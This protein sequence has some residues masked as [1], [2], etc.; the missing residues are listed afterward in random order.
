MNNPWQAIFLPL[1]VILASVGN[2]VADRTQPNVVIIYGDDVGYADVGV[3]GATKI[4][5]PNID[6]LAAQS[7][8][9]TDGHCSAST[10]TPSRFSLLTGVHAFRQGVRIAPPNASLLIST[11]AFTLPRLF[12]QAGYETGIVGK[13]HLGLGEKGQGPKWNGELKPGP[14]ELGFDSAFLLPTTNDRVP[15]V[16]VD[17]HRVVNLDSNDPIHVGGKAND[18]NKPGST[19]YPTAKKDAF[20]SSIVNGIGRIGYMSGGK[21]ALWDDY[22]MADVF[23]EKAVEFIAENSDKP[24]FLFFS[25]QDIHIPNAPN[26]R[27]QGSTNLG[28]RGDAMVQLDWTVGAIIAELDKQG[29]TDNTIVIFTSDNGPTHHDDTCESTKEVR[30]YS[31]KSGDGHDASGI[32]RGGK[33]EIYEGGTRVP[34]MIRWPHQIEPSTSAAMVNQ[35]DFI[36]SFAE[37][38]NVDLAPHQASDSRNTLAS[39]L[40]EDRRGLA[41]MLEES[42]GAALRVGDWKYIPGSVSI[43]PEGF[44]PVE[45]CLYNLSDDPSEQNNVVAQH[46]ERA[47]AMAAQLKKLVNSKGIR[48]QEIEKESVFSGLQ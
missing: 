39:F 36:A 10:C 33:Y 12:E 23:A 13:W 26:P 16:Y 27:F 44:F 40:G 15:C 45:D 29:L 4:A 6:A 22:T 43:R 2:A 7:L 19:Q 11:E 41:F 3:N 5:T 18:V 24:F 46:P 31:P 32:W 42:L 20:Y 21:S 47:T 1:L 17:G 30:R 37:L 28:A 48:N 34:L 38:L 25:S 9:F 35:I 8:N 14:L